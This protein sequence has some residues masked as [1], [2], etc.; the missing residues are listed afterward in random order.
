MFNFFSNCTLPPSSPAFVSGPGVRSTL[1]IVWSCF[2]TPILCS[3][4][5]L[6]LNIPE[7]TN[8]TK[9]QKWLKQLKHFIRKLK[10]MLV[11]LF[12]PEFML[13]KAVSDY[14]TGRKNN[15]ELQDC[16]R[17]S[18][19]SWSMT[20]THFA[21]MGGFVLQ[22]PSKPKTDGNKSADESAPGKETYVLTAASLREA[23]AIGVV[24][25][26]P[27]VDEEAIMDRSKSDLLVKGLSVA[28]VWW[29]AVQLLAR[30]ID[31]KP[32]SMLEVMTFSFAACAFIIYLLLISRPQDVR[33]PIYIDI[34]SAPSDSDM[35]RMG[36]FWPWPF[37]SNW[38]GTVGGPLRNN[39]IR[40]V[41]DAGH[42]VA[43]D[44]ALFSGVF[45]AILGAFISGGLHLIAWNFLFPSNIERILWIVSS[46]VTALMPLLMFLFQLLTLALP[47]GDTAFSLVQS[48]GAVLVFLTRL[49]LNV[50]AFRALYFL[51]PNAFWRPGQTVF[52]IYRGHQTQIGNNRDV[53][54]N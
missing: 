31:G 11:A 49:F 46:F 51:P 21:D 32:S 22:Y 8:P 41:C 3:W 28:Q 54:I 1:D 47:I 44:G 7:N 39:T 25:R 12:T 27:D 4:S 36:T 29:M 38:V 14:M 2:S 52:L 50:D 34:N 9:R 6:H 33:I 13:G 42:T 15:K 23:I 30:A 20:H 19:V 48:L 43:D 53:A 17:E 18:G 40:V 24:R 35:K 45:A 5:I 10:W 37:G 26:L 16:A